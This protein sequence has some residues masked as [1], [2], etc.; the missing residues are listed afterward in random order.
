MATPCCNDILLQTDADSASPSRQS[1]LLRICQ[2]IVGDLWCSCSLAR[3]EES[4]PI[5]LPLGNP[6]E[7]MQSG[8]LSHREF[9]PPHGSPWLHES[10][11][12]SLQTLTSC[13]FRQSSEHIQ[14]KDALAHLN[15]LINELQK[16]LNM[17]RAENA[18]IG[19]RGALPS[20]T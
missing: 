20:L 14:L 16:D 1:K 10:Q 3:H 11:Q 2:Q 9:L 15:L 7:R 12:I 6:P 17:F 5:G 13:P 19:S 8:R 18:G 4:H